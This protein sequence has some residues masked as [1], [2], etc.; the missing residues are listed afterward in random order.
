M[1]VLLIEDEPTWQISIRI[2]LEQLGWELLKISSSIESISEDIEETQPDLIISDIVLNDVSVF[3]LFDSATD[4]KIPIVF[5]T[6]FPTEGYYQS[7]IRLNQTALIIKPFHAL[8]LKSTVDL[9][10]KQTVKVKKPSEL[11][12]WVRNRYN[13][14][15]W[16]QEEN[17]LWVHSNGNYC[18][19]QTTT[20][21]YALKGA[22][23][24]LVQALSPSFIQIHRAY[25]INVQ[26]IQKVEL[27][28]ANLFINKQ[29]LP[30]SRKYKTQVVDYLVKKEINQQQESLR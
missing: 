11:G 19:I 14:K 30:I 4:V 26:H 6:N 18:F 25:L 21:K 17:I 7:A 22:L 1:K 16:V 27:S 8:T 10:C 13:Q 2:I 15:I 9:L 28:R 5:M 29:E 12:V 20:A 3:T 23:T 24:H